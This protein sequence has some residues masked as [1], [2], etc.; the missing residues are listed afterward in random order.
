MIKSLLFFI[1]L[2]TGVF[3]QNFSASVTFTG[4]GSPRGLTFGF[5]AYATDGYDPGYCSNSEIS[6]YDIC[7]DSG[8]EWILDAYAPPAPPI[9]FYC[10]TKIWRIHKIKLLRAAC[11]CRIKPSKISSGPLLSL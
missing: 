6:D 7:L 1:L 11:H 8:A 5:S 3:S 4:D 2:I 9:A 10:I